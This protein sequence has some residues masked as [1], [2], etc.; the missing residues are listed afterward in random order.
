VKT[1]TRGNLLCFG[2]IYNLFCSVLQEGGNSLGK[3]FLN[4]TEGCLL[5]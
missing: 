1:H 3:Y 2:S 4:E 5:K